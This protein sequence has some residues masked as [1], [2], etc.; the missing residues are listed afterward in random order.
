MAGFLVAFAALPGLAQ[1]TV[2]NGVR[3]G[4]SAA[5]LTESSEV[6]EPASYVDPDARRRAQITLSKREQA[7]REAKCSGAAPLVMNPDGSATELIPSQ[8]PCAAFET[9]A[10]EQS[11]DYA[12]SVQT[13]FTGIERTKGKTVLRRGIRDGLRQVYISYAATVE[14]LPDGTYRVSLGP[15]SDQPPADVR[16]KVGWRPTSPAAYPVPQTLKDED[17]LRLELYSEGQSRQL[18]DYIHV[19]REDRMVMRTEAARDYY[20]ED[21]ELSMTR[22]RVRLNGIAC[23]SMVELPDTI[24]GPVLWIYVPGHGRYVLSLHGFPNLGFE[25]AGEVASASLTFAAGGNVVRID[26]GERVAAGSGTYTL[27]VLADS[28]WTPA[29]SLRS[30]E[31][32]DRRLLA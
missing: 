18:V 30:D 7:L 12:E 1:S 6:R 29:V 21:A 25:S 3:V 9:W 31:D 5:Y 2:H 11:A 32:H 10:E 22:P 14:T 17:S 19:G 15:S 24:R 28:G 13:G 23:D 8:T 20:A 4:G 16:G 27:Y 26:T